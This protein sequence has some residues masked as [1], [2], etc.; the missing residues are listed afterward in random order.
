MSSD[1][2]TSPAAT[3]SG[4]CTVCN[5]GSATCSPDIYTFSKAAR[6]PVIDT[7][8]SFYGVFSRVYC[9]DA[10]TSSRFTPKFDLT[11][12]TGPLCSYCS[13]WLCNTPP[14]PS[15]YACYT[16][17]NKEYLTVHF[18]YLTDCA[19]AEGQVLPHANKGPRL[20][21]A[22]PEAFIRSQERI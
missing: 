22:V 11:R 3:S 20:V 8:C 13:Q 4:R 9:P 6:M 17:G 18:E 10:V 21:R 7:I 14:I 5:V 2:P 1:S 12:T 19:P 15:K 16:S